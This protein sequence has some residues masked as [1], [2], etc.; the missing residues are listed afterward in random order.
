MKKIT[1]IHR[2]ESAHLFCEDTSTWAVQRG[3][4]RLITNYLKTGVEINL[5]GIGETQSLLDTGLMDTTDSIYPQISLDAI[6]LR[7]T[8]GDAVNIYVHESTPDPTALL[9]ADKDGS[10]RRL[11]LDYST[12]IKF[13]SDDYKSVDTVVLHATGEVNIELGDT[14][15]MG[16]AQVDE[17]FADKIEVIGYSLLAYRYN[18][19]RVAA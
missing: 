18:A 15:V 9:S 19:N 3:Y 17:R 4:D 2:K 14:I 6:V 12:S 11:K 7:I 8:K 10:Y 1:P 13:Y 16:V 5:L